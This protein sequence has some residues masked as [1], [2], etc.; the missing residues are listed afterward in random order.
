MASKQDLDPRSLTRTMQH[1][2]ART[3]SGFGLPEL[4]HSTFHY[5]IQNIFNV[6]LCANP[7]IVVEA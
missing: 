6:S 1:V 2:A 4:E 3:T 7:N 5:K